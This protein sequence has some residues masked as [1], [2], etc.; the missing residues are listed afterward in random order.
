[1]CLQMVSLLLAALAVVVHGVTLDEYEVIMRQ[2]SDSHMDDSEDLF[3]YSA[4]LHN[5]EDPNT[6]GRTFT[7]KISSAR[8]V[9]AVC[10]FVVCSDCTVRTS[11][12]SLRM[13]LPA[14]CRRWEGA[15]RVSCRTVRARAHCKIDPIPF[16]H[17]CRHT[18]TQTHDIYLVWRGTRYNVCWWCFTMKQL[19]TLLVSSALHALIMGIYKL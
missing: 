18:Y 16:L 13:C 3:G 2:T 14:V 5:T 6:P 8:C 15:C 12:S 4:A 17:P 1:M 19:P 11:G 9:K 10:V 7:Q